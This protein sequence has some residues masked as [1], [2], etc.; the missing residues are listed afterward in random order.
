MDSEIVDAEK[1]SSLSYAAKYALSFELPYYAKYLIVA[2]FLASFNSPKEDK[3]LFV[4]L[5]GRTKKRVQKSNRNSQ[6]KIS[7][8][9]MGPRLFDLERLL[10]IFYSIIDEKPHISANLLTQVSMTLQ[11]MP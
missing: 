4:K 2:A 9:V 1:H 8:L 3:R 5:S 10:A 6:P 7:S 11:Q